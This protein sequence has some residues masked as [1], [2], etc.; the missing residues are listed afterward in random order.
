MEKERSGWSLCCVT[1]TAMLRRLGASVLLAS[2]VFAGCFTSVFLDRLIQRQEESLQRMIETTRINCIVTDS[3]GMNSGK[4]DMFA[5]FVDKLM[6]YRH[7][8]GCYLD[9][10]VMDVNAISTIPLQSPDGVRLARITTLA[11]DSR[12]SYIEGNEVI[13]CKGWS[14]SV[15]TGSEKVCIVTEDIQT[16]T[17]SDGIEWVNVVKDKDSSADLRVIGKVQGRLENMIYCPFYLSFREDV[18]EL[19]RVESCSFY[20]RDNRRLEESKAAIYEEF[21]TPSLSNKPESLTYGVIVQDETYLKALEEIQSNLKMLQLLPPVLFIL[22]GCIGFFASYMTTRS[23]EKEFAVSRCLGMTQRRI[24]TLV[25]MEQAVLAILGGAVGIGLG[26]C[27]EQHLSSRAVLKTG[28][29]VTVFLI[30][31]AI[32]T[33]RVTSV[34]VMKLMKVEG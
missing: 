22:T 15:L 25:F 27:M 30:G 23:R 18:T 13:W 32:A 29:V 17:D 1:L 8:Q 10:Y 26:L 2:V 19:Y 6:G 34:N 7:E 28:L 20:I 3:Q 12:L 11:S 33:I 16:F 14:E 4:L 24:F 5:G 9:E 31:A 21:V